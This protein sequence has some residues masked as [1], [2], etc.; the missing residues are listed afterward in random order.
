MDYV[1][2]IDS[3]ENNQDSELSKINQKATIH[4]LNN[5]IFVNNSLLSEP[6]KI[7]VLNGNDIS[8][9]KNFDNTLFYNHNDDNKKM[10]SSI[11]TQ[12]LIFIPLVSIKILIPF[13]FYNSYL[14][15]SINSDNQ[16]QE[17]INDKYY[18]YTL[19]LLIFLC[20][21]LS[22]KTSSKQMKIE[23]YIYKRINN[24]KNQNNEIINDNK[25]NKENTEN[26]DNSDNKENTDNKENSENNN[27]V[28]KD[29]NN[30]TNFYDN[31]DI[32][33][34]Y[35]NQVKTFIN[36]DEKLSE[37]ITYFD[38]KNYNQICNYC[39]IRSFIRATH[40]LI[41]DECILFKEE[42]CPYIANCIGFNNLQYFINL[43][44]WCIY[45][46]VY[47]IIVCIK[48]FIKFNIKINIFILIILISDFSINLII[49]RALII[50]LYKLLYNIYYNVTQYEL[51]MEENNINEKKSHNLFNIGFYNHFYY[52]IG[53]TPFHFLFPLPKIKNYGNDENCP[54]FLKCKFP[55]RLELVKYL[56]K[57]DPKYKEF[58]NEVESDPNNYIKLCHNFYDDKN[59]E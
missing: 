37:K 12:C 47:Y 14:I 1:R 30:A 31:S 20:Y 40:C 26:K 51:Q 50:K 29:N 39:H 8:I 15:Y 24:S 36:K 34:I 45:G 6:V 22:I 54:I 55:N 58:L 46:L 19:L 42:H 33:N 16:E 23:K 48:S 21:I 2:K 9:N 53:P 52:L 11:K 25:E 7:N 28:N 38:L 44:F 10:N 4:S 13:L 5:K 18:S 3:N 41:C 27:N 57:R 43:L 35:Y 32:E 17:N 56:A 59:I 49:L